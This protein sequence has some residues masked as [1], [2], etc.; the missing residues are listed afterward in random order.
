MTRITNLG[1]GFLFFLTACGGSPLV[2]PYPLASFSANRV[3]VKIMLLWDDSG[4][5]WLEATFMP[6]EGHH[7]LEL[8]P[9]SQWEAMGEL[10]ASVEAYEDED[11]EGLLAYPE[12]PVTLRLPV[13]LPEG[14][15][16]FDEQVSITF[17]AC[18]EGTCCPPVVEKMIPVRVPGAEEIK[19]Q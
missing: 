18:R 12:G 16:W 6:E 1:L 3:S 2:S 4:E 13:R 9:G 14:E 11:C 7:L 8:V 5:A 19:G 17:M 10:T 15:G